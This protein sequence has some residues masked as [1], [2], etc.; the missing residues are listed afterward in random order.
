MSERTAS[1]TMLDAAWK[2]RPE[3]STCRRRPPLLSR[4]AFAEDRQR[5]RDRVTVSMS[6]SRDSA[7][8]R[9]QLTADNRR[10]SADRWRDCSAANIP[11]VSPKT[12]VYGLL[13]Y[14]DHSLAN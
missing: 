3:P 2:S 1:K 4:S 14:G 10:D 12:R 13:A 6:A 7:M 8:D 9:D 5:L 11:R